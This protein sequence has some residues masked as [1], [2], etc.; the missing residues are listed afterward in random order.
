MKPSTIPRFALPVPGLAPYDAADS[1]P[2]GSACRLGLIP[3]HD[4]CRLSEEE[5]LDWARVGVSLRVGGPRY[6]F[7]TRWEGRVRRTTVAWCVA[8]VEFVRAQTAVLPTSGVGA[9]PTSLSTA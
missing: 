2:L 5:L 3:G 8:W 1:L 4:G 6:L 7:P 9:A